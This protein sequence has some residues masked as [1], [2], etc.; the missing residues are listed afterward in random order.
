M[1]KLSLEDLKKKAIVGVP[2]TNMK[3]ERGAVVPKSTVSAMPTKRVATK[4]FSKRLRAR[5]VAQEY[6]RNGMNLKAAYEKVTG[7]PCKGNPEKKL[8]DAL[9]DFIA[10]ISRSIERPDIGKDK[11]VALLWA[12]I[13]VSPL[14]FMD[15]SGAPMTIEQLKKLPR[16]IQS[17]IES[18]SIET[19]H[20]IVRD[21]NGKKVKNEN[22]EYLFAPV[23]RANVRLMQKGNLMS[24]LAQIM[25]W[26]GPTVQVNN[27]TYN[28]G[29]MMVAA[30]QNRERAMAAIQQRT[31]EGQAARVEGD[32]P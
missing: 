21:E 30:D 20:E 7:L 24:Q 3:F 16:E 23:L 9:T 11:A 17:I 19:H 4:H 18:V 14:D 10:E 32:E 27:N 2:A 13:T 26:V 25:K 31:I 6:L 29:T 12:G 28:I 8:G 15:D 5:L 22:G 1:S